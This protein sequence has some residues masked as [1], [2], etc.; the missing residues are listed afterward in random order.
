MSV[1]ELERRYRT[2]HEPHER[3]WWQILWLLARGQLAKEFADST[4]YSHY[5]IGWIAKRYNAEGQ[6]GMH[7]R[8]YT[9]SHRAVP[10]LSPEY[11]AELAAAVRGPAPE[12]ADWTGA[13]G[14]GVDEP[15]ARASG[16][17]TG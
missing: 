5:W 4:G 8:Q 13:R 14:G 17:R 6:E 15:E 2:A 1:D 7:N 10:L 11:L 3:T 9:Y 16:E 12:G